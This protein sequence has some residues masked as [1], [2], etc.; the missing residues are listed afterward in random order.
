MDKTPFPWIGK[1]SAELNELDAIPLFGNTPS[2]DW[3]H[4]ASLLSSCFKGEIFLHPIKREWKTPEEL[5]KELGIHPSTVAIHVS[6]LGASLLW[7]MPRADVDK[8]TSHM[9]YEKGK[10]KT[11]EMIREGF[12]RYLLLESL[13]AASLIEPLKELT[14]QLEEESALPFENVFCIGIEIKIDD[15]TCWGTLMIPA[16]FRKKWV[17]HFSQAPLDYFSTDTAKKTEIILSV[18]TAQSQLTQKEWSQFEPGDFLLLDHN[19]YNAHRE[20]GVAFL[21]MGST[22]L[23]QVK[24]K[25]NKIELLNYAYAYEETMEYKNS[26]PL[27]H[28]QSVEETVSSIKDIPFNV[29]VELARFQMSLDRLMHLS[30]CQF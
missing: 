30:H 4:L 3:S 13:S 5:K 22:P 23:F 26:E 10:G 14:L 27:N 6:P 28:L 19:A 1:I 15:K 24:I 11:S 17:E 20:T 7:S 9:L 18:Q 2:F 8:L 12:Y 21:K 16:S 25:H 29:T